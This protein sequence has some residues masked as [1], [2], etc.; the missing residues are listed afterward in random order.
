MHSLISISPS[1]QVEAFYSLN[2]PRDLSQLLNIRYPRLIY[3]LYKVPDDDK[4][5]IFNIPKRSGGVREIQAP[6][7]A[8]KIIQKKLNEVLLNV[9]KVKPSVFSYVRNRSIVDNALKHRRKR[10]VFN[11]DLED[12]FPSINFGRVRGLFIGPPYNL[13]ESVATVFAQICC[14]NNQLP[15]GAPTSSIVSN[16]ICAKM[17]SELQDLAMNNRCYYTRYSDDITFSTSLPDFPTSIG[18]SITLTDSV[19][20]DDLDRVISE[21]GFKINKNK[22]RLQLWFRRQQ[23]T[24][25]TVN[26]FPNVRRTYVRQIRA[27]LHA[28]RKHGL[29]N[30]EQV[31]FSEYDKK[32]RNPN[33][34]LPSFRQIVKGKIDFLGMVRG[35]QNEIY[36]KFLQKYKSLESRDKGIP[37]LNIYDISEIS[38][39]R[40]VTEGKFDKQVLITAWNKLYENA[41]LPFKI[42]ESDPLSKSVSIGGSGGAVALNRLLNAQ[43]EDTPYITIGIFDRDYEGERQ[44]KDLSNDYILDT[45]NDWK[46]SPARKAG[47]FLLPVP[48]DKEGY[49]HY[50][51]L[52]IEFL[53]SEEVLSKKTEKGLGLSFDFP[54]AKIKGM[55]VLEESQ[56]EV[57][58]TRIIKSGKAEFANEIVPALEESEFIHFKIIFEKITDIINQFHTIIED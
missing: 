7:S 20:G 14:F 6:I 36:Q 18:I 25:L 39:P 38:M 9:Y 15:Q 49:A 28:W 24:G 27:M 22:V 54:P 51:N 57:L 19:P 33:L 11:V 37:S 30:A 4:Y 1:E 50:K 26:E 10:Y 35:K 42:K 5:T 29:I 3:H 16:M 23:V 45:E 55:P 8:I 32:Y 34:E 52:S 56:I 47:A 21:N 12:F 40:V 53:F 13:P 2:S 46:L 31:Y 58:D 44:F 41:P 43:S 48:T 17:D